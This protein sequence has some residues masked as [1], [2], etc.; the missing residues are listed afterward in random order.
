[1]NH[2]FKS[3]FRNIRKYGIH[4]FLN[5]TGMAIGMASAILILL[6]VENEWSYDRH[7]RNADNLY[8][9]I[10]K[11]TALGVSMVAT[12]GA[13]PHVLKEEYPEIIRATRYGAPPDF[14]LQR[15]DEFIEEKVA[16]VDT[17]FLK[18]FDIEFV[19]GDIGNALKEPRNIVI[20]E[21]MAVKYP[22]CGWRAGCVYRIRYCKRYAIKQPDTVWF[23]VSH[24]MERIR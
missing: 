1:M 20:T 5:I 4:S 8:R 9:I 22:D 18:M 7:F 15:D 11:D 6:W 13:L 14:I 17:D 21:K 3:S 23:Y 2:F 12:A 24:G 19:R 16:M 10:Q